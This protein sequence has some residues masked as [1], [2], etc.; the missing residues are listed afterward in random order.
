VK[1]DKYSASLAWRSPK[2]ELF[3]PTTSPTVIILDE[4]N[5]SNFERAANGRFIRK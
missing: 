1:N 4:F 5:S 2:P 3:L